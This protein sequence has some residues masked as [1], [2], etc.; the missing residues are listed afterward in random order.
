[1]VTMFVGFH[2]PYEAP[3][4]FRGLFLQDSDASVRERKMVIRQSSL[5]SRA[6]FEAIQNTF[7]GSGKFGITLLSARGFH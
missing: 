4:S 1:M 6:A 2:P 3:S 7:D 5:P